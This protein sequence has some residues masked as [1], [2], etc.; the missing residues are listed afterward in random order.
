[1]SLRKPWPRKSMFAFPL[2]CRVK[3]ASPAL[4]RRGA[5]LG[6][7]CATALAVLAAASHAAQAGELAVAPLPD[8]RLQLFVIQQGQLMTAWKR[9]RDANSQW[10]PLAAFDPA[11]NGEIKDVAVGRLPDGRLQLFVIGPDGLATAWKQTPNPGSGWTVWS[12]FEV[13]PANPSTPPGNSPATTA[14]SI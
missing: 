12:P 9:N 1:M 3:P 6:A 13:S 4:P 10:T 5:L 11:P 8:G 7:L 14:D 2:P